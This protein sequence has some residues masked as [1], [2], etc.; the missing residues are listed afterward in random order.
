MIDKPIL[1]S[2]EYERAKKGVFGDFLLA[3]RAS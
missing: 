1:Y 2:V 3:Y